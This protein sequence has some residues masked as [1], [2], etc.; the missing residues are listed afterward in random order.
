MKFGI[1]TMHRVLNFGSALQ[2]YAL[3]KVLD[4]IGCDN[5]IIDYIFPPRRPII[6]RINTRFHFVLYQLRTGT[7]FEKS[8]SKFFADFY[9]HFLRLSLNRYDKNNI[10]KTNAIYDAFITGSD[11]V[12]N[13]TWIKDDTSFL[14]SFVD[15]DKP[16]YSY[17]SSFAISNI[18]ES[19]KCTYKQYLCG[20]NRITVREGSG[21][22][23]VRN[24][25]GNEPDLVLDPTLLLSKDDYQK[26]AKQSCLH[27]DGNYILVYMLTYMYNPFPEVNGIV[28]QVHEK[29]GGKVVYLGT[30]RFSAYSDDCICV[31]NLGPCEFISLIENASFVITSSFHGTA[32]AS[33]FNKPL[34]STVKSINDNDGRMPTLLGMIGG[35]KSIVE[36]K[37]NDLDLSN[38]E[39]YK[40]SMEKMIQ[41]REKS[42]ATLVKM[43]GFKYEKDFVNSGSGL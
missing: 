14:L 40:C 22:N 28:R 13:P 42:L 19:Y 9:N 15:D 32:F 16:K 20:Y 25:I 41:Q 18:P 5:E 3:Q 33:I 12:W 1:I 23:I 35:E 7:F 17:A 30:G 43:I 31:E 24:L 36:Y 11:Q 21:V 4:N 2:A 39:L 38:I 8:K 27:I 34:I 37:A 10:V 29:L 6:E 26:L